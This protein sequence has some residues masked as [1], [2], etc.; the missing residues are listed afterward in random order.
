VAGDGEGEAAA[1]V[2]G[3]KM[4][5]VVEAGGVA[6]GPVGGGVET[7]TDEDAGRAMFFR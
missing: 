1:G 3:V 5:G 6:F 2:G 4:E 7:V